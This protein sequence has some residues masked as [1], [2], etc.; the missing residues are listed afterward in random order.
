MEDGQLP[1][2]YACAR[3]TACTQVVALLLQEFPDAARCA[4]RNKKMLPVH[5]A[6]N[7]VAAVEIVFQLLDI[8]PESAGIKAQNDELALH[9]ACRTNMSLEVIKRLVEL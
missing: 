3:R 7:K 9:I 8:Y 6:L 5:V 4:S 1:I 2:H